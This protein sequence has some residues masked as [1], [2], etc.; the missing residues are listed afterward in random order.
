M[1]G[2]IS[3]QNSNGHHMTQIQNGDN[4]SLK[5]KRQNQ[6]QQNQQQ[7]KSFEIPQDANIISLDDD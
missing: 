7:Q 3:I 1:N 2:K 5:E 4:S 6:Q